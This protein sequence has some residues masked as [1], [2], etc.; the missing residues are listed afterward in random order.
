LNI[1]A[2]TGYGKTP[3]NSKDERDYIRVL[4][5]NFSKALEPFKTHTYTYPFDEEVANSVFIA[6]HTEERNRTQLFKHK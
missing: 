2:S 6:L 4:K 5:E 1:E 3:I